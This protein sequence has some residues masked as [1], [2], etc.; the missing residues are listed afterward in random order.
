MAKTVVG[1]FD[2]FA[3][4]QQAVDELERSGYS[5]NDISVVAN[6]ESHSGG[7]TG[8]SAGEQ[9]A[10]VGKGA[11]AGAG[12]GAAVGGLTG[13]LAGLG[14]MLIP[15]I[16]PVLA[17]GPLSAAL[18]GAAIGAAGGGVIGGLTGL[19]IP[20]EHAELYAEGVRRG[21]T[22]VVVKTDDARM[23]DV[24]QILDRYGAVDVEQR[25]AQYRQAGYTGFRED[26]QPY[27]VDQITRE[28]ESYRVTA[29]DVP[30]AAAT[31]TATT[32]TTTG[33]TD[34]TD[35]GEV[36]IP[37]VE[38]QIAVGKREV[39]RGRVRVY[40]HVEEIPVQEQVNLREEQVVVERRPVDRAASTADV[41][42]FREGTIEITERAEEA[43]VAKQARVVE[44]VVIDKEVAE[45]T[46]T[47]H[48]TVRRT[49]VDVEELETGDTSVTRTTG[50]TTTTGTT[51]TTGSGV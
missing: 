51:G 43:V 30:A 11:L 25:G 50:T 28:R 23:D 22:L 15:G 33:T 9:A 12:T 18:T 40:T 46:E 39:E 17:I 47:V 44:E 24:I 16:G 49:D 4:A 20:K 2:D 13:L 1:L 32:T 19:G 7:Q 37:I 36:T 38:E 27:T 10:G 34:L 8:G 48:D 26:A 42:A 5:H 6:Q 31:T 3:S 21:G 29:P 14:A 41:D 45:R 35:R